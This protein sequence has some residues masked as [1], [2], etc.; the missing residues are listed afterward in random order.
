MGHLISI[1]PEVE[2]A[3]KQLAFGRVADPLNPL[4]IAVSCRPFLCMIKDVIMH[5]GAVGRDGRAVSRVVS[6][7]LKLP[8][9]FAPDK[10]A[11][12]RFIEFFTANTRFPC[13][14]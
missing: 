6:G 4:K 3:Y 5:N 12:R 14:P 10:D 2:Q 1:V 7:S 8:V 11:A 13:R 9:L